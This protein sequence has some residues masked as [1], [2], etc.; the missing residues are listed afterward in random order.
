MAVCDVIGCFAR[1][2]KL[3]PGF[4]LVRLGDLYV[5]NVHLFSI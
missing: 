3:L 4:F 5:D 2:D 1:L